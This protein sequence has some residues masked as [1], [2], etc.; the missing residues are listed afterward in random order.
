MVSLMR[1]IKK[2]FPVLAVMALLVLQAV[3]VSCSQRPDMAPKYRNILLRDF[4]T[5]KDG[6]VINYNIGTAAHC[7]AT[8]SVLRKYLPD[9]VDITV[10]ADEPLC[11]ELREM[12][13]CRWPDVRFVYGE[14]DADAS[15]ELKAAVD[16]SDLLLVSSG[17]GVANSVKASINAYRALTGK[18]VAAY[19][20]GGVPSDILQ[21]MDFCWIRD[22][23]ALAKYAGTPSVCG[24][25]PDAVFDFDCRDD[26]AAEH[27]ISG[28]SLQEGGFICLIPGYR[29]TPR[30]EY[31]G[32]KVDKRKAEANEAMAEADNSILR[33]IAVMAV[34][35]KG[36]KVLICAEQVPELKL[37]RDVVYA[38]L[39]EDVKS[40]C[41]VLDS[42]WSPQMAL[43]VYVKSAAVIGIEMH[44]QV[45][46]L[47]NGVPSV[48]LRHSGF[49]TK[50]DMWRTIGLGE[51]LF[52]ID[53]PGAGECSCAAVRGILDNK[54]H[55]DSLVMAARRI[56]DD[57]TASAIRQSFFVRLLPKSNGNRT[58]D[59]ENHS[60]TNDSIGIFQKNV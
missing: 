60:D 31:F 4:R 7:P 53:E 3:A 43:G 23:K 46:A 20:V 36:M 21:V 2:I 18:S 52:D 44:S 40:Q 45:M 39:P 56:I 25:A 12:M 33:D 51:W 32:G 57:S 26:E 1:K 38:H 30:W 16:R 9:E 49:G 24:W 58:I 55:A 34:R 41:V 29:F 19:A 15:E 27:F 35:E 48:I 5:V 47:G 42:W 10:W 14:L 22:E 13:A 6:M 11:P 28:N 17:S 54:E 8:L 37:A 59:Q 50:S